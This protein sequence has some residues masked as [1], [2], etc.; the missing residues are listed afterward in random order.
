MVTCFRLV[1]LGAMA[2][3][4]SAFLRY[5]H[6]LN[7]FDP[8]MSKIIASSLVVGVLAAAAEVGVTTGDRDFRQSAHGGALARAKQ[9][10]MNLAESKGLA[11]QDSQFILIT[12][13]KP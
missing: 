6:V 13:S 11:N 2:A 3:G 10:V 12:R 1:Q 4:A 8:F 7:D 5:F 9:D